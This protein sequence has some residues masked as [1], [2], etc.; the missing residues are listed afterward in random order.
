M[1]VLFSS[2]GSLISGPQ[3]LYIYMLR[4]RW[5]LG[6]ADRAP[7]LPP[8]QLQPLWF[9]YVP[10]EKQKARCLSIMSRLKGTLVL[11]EALLSVLTGGTLA[12]MGHE[13]NRKNQL[14]YSSGMK[15]QNVT[16]SWEELPKHQLSGCLVSWL[17]KCWWKLCRRQSPSFTLIPWRKTTGSDRRQGRK[18]K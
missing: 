9:P 13:R 5:H 4:A 14:F 7:A 17:A 2:N 10:K 12:I 3:S 16:F 8:H 15:L 6:S 1:D 11:H 18:R